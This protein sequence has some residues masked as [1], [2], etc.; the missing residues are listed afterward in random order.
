MS[1]E[2]RSFNLRIEG[3]IW[4]VLLSVTLFVVINADELRCEERCL[5]LSIESFI[6][7]VRF[8]A[9]V[10]VGSGADELRNEQ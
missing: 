7:S 4:S 1:I 2:K 10:F 8:S 6:W 9:T 5:I 3:F